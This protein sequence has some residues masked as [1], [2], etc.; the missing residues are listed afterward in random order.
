MY[1]LHRWHQKKCPTDRKKSC[2]ALQTI[3]LK[4]GH[5]RKV[6]PPQTG[7]NCEYFY[8]VGPKIGYIL[9][10][11]LR[12]KRRQK[13]EC[14]FLKIIFQKSSVMIGGTSASLQRPPRAWKRAAREFDASEPR[15]ALPSYF[16]RGCRCEHRRCERQKPRK[17]REPAFLKIHLKSA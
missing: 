14:V 3:V 9:H 5:A 7:I 16:H 4:S 1:L 10:I 17:P 2:W 6:V 13:Y 8:N 15:Q 12:K 11:L